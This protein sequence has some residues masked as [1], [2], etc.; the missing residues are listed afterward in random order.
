MI[1]NIHISI[2]FLTDQDSIR[3]IFQLKFRMM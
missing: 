2:D 1:S 3:Y